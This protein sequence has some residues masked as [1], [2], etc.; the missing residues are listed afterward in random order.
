MAVGKNTS[1]P[2][3]TWVLGL[4][5]SF[6][7]KISLQVLSFL[8]GKGVAGACGSERIASQAFD[9]ARSVPTELVL[10]W[11]LEVGFIFVETFRFFVITSVLGMR[12]FLLLLL[13]SLSFERFLACFIDA[14]FHE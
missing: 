10:R 1:S 6:L 14:F 8:F 7:A 13:G 11:S 12:L 2:P 5:P 4:Q 9:P 3:P